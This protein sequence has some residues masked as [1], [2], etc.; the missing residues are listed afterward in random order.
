MG[1]GERRS[2]R[3]AQSGQSIPRSVWRWHVE[4]IIV[5]N[6]LTT[7]QKAQP[8]AVNKRVDAEDTDH[9]EV[10]AGCPS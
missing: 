3:K 4:R 1:R 7:F 8:E 5:D 10:E 6:R 9:V 2:V